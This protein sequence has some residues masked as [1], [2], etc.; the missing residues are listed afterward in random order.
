MKSQNVL[1][2]LWKRKMTVGTRAPRSGPQRGFVGPGTKYRFG[3][4]DDVIRVISPRPWGPRPPFGAPTLWNA[5]SLHF[6]SSNYCSNPTAVRYVTVYNLRYVKNVKLKHF[7]G[8]LSSRGP[9]A[10][11]PPAPPLGGPA[12]NSLENRK[13]CL[14]LQLWE[15][16]TNFFWNCKHHY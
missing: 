16:K 2:F 12:K 13:K 9:G 11:C 10:S 5:V 6:E 7:R 14:L 3:A 4:L 8:P 15:T 1:R